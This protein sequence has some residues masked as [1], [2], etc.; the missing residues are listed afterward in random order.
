MSSV[1]YQVGDAVGIGDGANADTRG[2]NLNMIIGTTQDLYR[3]L[4]LYADIIRHHHLI[5]VRRY[6]IT[7]TA[8][9]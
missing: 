2:Q 9:A 8:F 5:P 3:Y 1:S 7:E 6:N 4:Q